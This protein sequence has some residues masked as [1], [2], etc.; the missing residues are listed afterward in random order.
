MEVEVEVEMKVMVEVE[1]LG[2][3]VARM[4]HLGWRPSSKRVEV[5]ASSLTT[6]LVREVRVMMQVRKMMVMM[7]E[8]PVLM[9]QYG[10]QDE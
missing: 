1:Q 8:M 9:M 2:V 7:I 10:D 6:L 4:F 3:E 5:L